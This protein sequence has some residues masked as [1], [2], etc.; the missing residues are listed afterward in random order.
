MGHGGNQGIQHMTR[1]FSAGDEREVAEAIAAA[2]RDDRPL[3]IRASATR[4]RLGRP[5]A[6]EDVLDVS[7]LAGVAMYEPE[8]LVFT[9]RAAT[10]LADIEAMLAEHNQML[11]FEPPDYA[12]LFGRKAG[13]GTLGGMTAVGLAGPRRIRAGSVRDHLLGFRAVSGRAEVFKSGG[14][15]MKN[16]TGFDLSKLMCGSH[17]TLAVLT[18]LTFK[19]LPAAERTIT[20]R[21]AGLDEPQAQALMTKALQSPA[22]VSAAAHLPADVNENGAGATL[23]RLEGFTA[24]IAARRAMLEE[25]LAEFGAPEMIE[26]EENRRLWRAIANVEPLA[27]PADHLIWRIVCAPA[28]G[29]EV[30]RAL[31]AMPGGARLFM[32]W[33][34]GLI[35]LAVPPAAHAMA[36]L[37]R[38]ALASISGHAML[39]RAPEELR[40]ALA[41]FQPQPEALAAVSE[42]I[43][44][45]FDPADILNPGVIHPSAKREG[46]A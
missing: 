32:D 39:F 31:R 2:L 27:E 8:E 21:Y 36:E 45:A 38:G 19:V 7:A 15:V 4:A 42:R 24:S 40:R 28:Q 25:A 1:I 22:G 46:A 29:A 16:V 35:W 30:A 14:R 3:R 11:A 12:A 34:G 10:P 9:A 20:L 26:G 23:L 33:G 37:V 6:A 5:P 13:R 41:V 43:R 44:A 18:E 17:G